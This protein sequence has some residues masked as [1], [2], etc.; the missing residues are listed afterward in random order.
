MTAGFFRIISIAVDKFF[1]VST[2]LTCNKLSNRGMRLLISAIDNSSGLS[3]NKASTNFCDD[4]FKAKNLIIAL[5][6]L[7][8]TY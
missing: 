5:P 8:A 7:P 1:T 6:V 3:E 2:S 4:S